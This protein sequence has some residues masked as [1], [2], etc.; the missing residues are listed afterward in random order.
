MPAG[1]LISLSATQPIKRT[2]TDRITMIDPYSIAG[3]SALGLNNE[4]KFAFANAPGVK[5]EWLEDSYAGRSTTINS[6]ALTSDSALTQITVTT[7]AYFKAGDVILIDDEYM[8][9]TAHASNVLDVSR[10]WSGTQATHANA[11]T[12]Y[13]VGQAR[14]EGTS[15]VDSNFTEPATGYNFS[16]ILQKSIEVSRSNAL[17]NRYGIPNVVD[18]EIDKAMDEL[19]MMLNLMLYHGVRVA[20]STSAPYASSFGGLETFISTN[21]STA[22]SAALTQKMIEDEIAQCYDAGGAPNLILCNTWAKRK[23]A[24]FYEGSIR[25]ERSESTGGM[26]IDTI[27]SAVGVPLNIVLDRHCP[28][29]TLYL[30][31]TRYLGFITLDP[32]FEE[33]LGKSKDTAYL[34]QVVGEYGFVVQFEKAHSFIYAISTT[35]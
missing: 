35:A 31:D 24:S 11:S 26:S 18:R 7:G 16:S 14:R 32:F 13:L 15:A 27:M 8:R 9:V 23:I 19:M 20:G 21:P 6:T 5:Y 29:D 12:V 28:T 2:V 30:L 17:L 25:T 3:I 10:D 33:E 1:Q 34:G 4:S 22:S